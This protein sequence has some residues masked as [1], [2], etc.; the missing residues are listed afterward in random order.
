MSKDSN[1]PT[2]S[3]RTFVARLTA[4]FPPGTL[5]VAVGLIATGLTAYAYLILTARVLGPSR[6]TPFFRYFGRWSFWLDPK[7]SYHSSRKSEGYWLFVVL[8]VWVVVV[9]S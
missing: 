5:P 4:L 9:Q 1:N 8:M 7:S 6:Y 3:H 2:A